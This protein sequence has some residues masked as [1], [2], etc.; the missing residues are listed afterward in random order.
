MAD[1]AIHA[2]ADQRYHSA[3]LS[4]GAEEATAVLR[5]V[6][7]EYVIGYGHNGSLCKTK[8]KIRKIRMHCENTRWWS[9]LCSIGSLPNRAVYADAR[10]SHTLLMLPV[11][12]RV[13]VHSLISIGIQS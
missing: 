3:T 2:E 12:M 9:A 4:P 13:C 11:Y 10:S 5:G 7:D 6:Q 8:N 1:S